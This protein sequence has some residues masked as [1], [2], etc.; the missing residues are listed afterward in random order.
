[1]I[2]W[3]NQ[4]KTPVLALDT[5]SGVDLNDGVIHDP[6][7][8]ADATLTLALPKQGLFSDEVKAI[9]G[10]LYLAD[11]GVPPILYQ[12]RKLGLKVAPIFAFGD[13]LLIDEV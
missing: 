12:E 13:I 1:M 8:K 9:R 11:I 5:P 3:A 2:E 4:Q 6:V 10:P 7:I